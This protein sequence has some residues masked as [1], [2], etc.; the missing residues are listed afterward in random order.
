MTGR[1]GFLGALFGAASAAVLDPE[2]L[3]WVPGAKT[4]SIP[5]P[6]IPVA[7]IAVPQME[8]G[9]VFTIAGYFSVNPRTRKQETKLQKFVVR[10]VVIGQLGDIRY[11]LRMQA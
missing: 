3:L 1:R 10:E 8:V 11:D 4:I 7:T 5:A 6:I 2:R 9:D